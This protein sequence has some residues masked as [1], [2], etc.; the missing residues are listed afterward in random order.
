VLEVQG[1]VT[2]PLLA[3][4]TLLALA[5]TGD[6]E[7]F[8]KLTEPFRRELQVHCYRLLGSAQDAEDLLQETLIAA[9]RGI[10]QFEGRSSLRAWLY[11][12]A[13][14]Q[15]L[16]AL[17]D[18]KARALA[19]RRGAAAVSGATGTGVAGLPAG[20]PALPA[21]AS[22]DEPTWLEPYPDELLAGLADTAPGP[23]A[24]YESRESISLAFIT[25]L[26]HLTPG[27]RA[28]LVL[29]DALGYRAAE[30]AEILDCSLDTVNGS[31]KR[32]RAAVSALLPGDTLSQAPLPGS[33]AEREV[34]GRFTDAFERGDVATLVSML[35]DD[36]WLTMPPWPL[37]F[38]G[39]A[40]AAGLLTALVFQGGA[41]RI[42]LVP[43]GAN[44]QPAFACYVSDGAAAVASGSGL[45]VP[46]LA[47]TRI[48]G[49]TRFL[50]NGL[51]ARFGLPASLP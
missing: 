37:G 42:R 18:R 4:A 3:D 26:Q 25:A 22:D 45:I 11:R 10:G 39:P 9:W 15:C 7:A 46:T 43:V 36:A 31:L 29:R 27:Q 32:A 51:L 44:R 21:P 33:A 8:G 2:E 50:D 16:N 40:A 47:G 6:G 19:A 12:I 28:A 5:Q 23:E 20:L 34:I 17:R 49:V 13:T 14:N 35:T 30:A 38:R 48:C 24:R 1:P 41:L